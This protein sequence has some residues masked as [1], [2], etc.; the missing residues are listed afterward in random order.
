MYIS[1]Q[2]LGMVYSGRD[3]G[4]P[5]ELYSGRDLKSHPELPG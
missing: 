1:Q 5:L 2:F 3:L 4:L